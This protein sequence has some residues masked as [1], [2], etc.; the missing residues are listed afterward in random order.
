MLGTKCRPQPCK[1]SAMSLRAIPRRSGSL[2][3][4]FQWWCHK[5]YDWNNLIQHGSFG[6]T[7]DASEVW[8]S[9]PLFHPA[10]LSP[11][12]GSDSERRIWKPP[13]GLSASSYLTIM[14][15]VGSGARFGR[16]CLDII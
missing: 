6:I 1:T 7:L 8:Q 14:Y 11:S 3:P 13:A 9:W 16:L 5:S 10:E 4:L 2:P 15:V 12:S